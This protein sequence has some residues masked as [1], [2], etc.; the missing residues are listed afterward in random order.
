MDAERELVDGGLLAA[1]VEDP[2]LGVGD[3]SAETALGVRL[4]LAVAVATGRSAPHLVL[5]LQRRETWVQILA[6]DQ[7][8][9]YKQLKRRSLSKKLE[10]LL[11]FTENQAK[12][13][14]ITDRRVNSRRPTDLN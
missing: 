5:T 3:T 7:S 4:V 8:T 12:V 6:A 9:N 14:V 13:Y 2:D 11:T 1:Q 10:L